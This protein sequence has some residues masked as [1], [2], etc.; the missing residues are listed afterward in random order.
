MAL[1]AQNDSSGASI[2]SSHLVGLPVFWHDAQRHA[3][4]NEWKKWIYLFQVAIM[5]NYSISIAEMSREVTEL[6]PRMRS[7]M[8]GL[9]EDR[10]MKKL[11]SAMY[12]F[13]G[14]AAR[15]QFRDKFPYTICLGIE[16]RWPN[17][18]E[19]RMFFKEK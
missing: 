19:H 17:P 4:N 13:L 6:L 8:G 9:D 14:E 3:N 12:L 1:R 11:V 7:L 15:K 10:A 16:S 18:N 2:S 5:A